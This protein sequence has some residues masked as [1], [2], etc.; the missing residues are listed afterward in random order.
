M[1]C[2]LL[3]GKREKN[4]GIIYDRIHIIY[5]LLMKATIVLVNVIAYTRP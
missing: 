3:T 1:S 4:L 2:I 5:V